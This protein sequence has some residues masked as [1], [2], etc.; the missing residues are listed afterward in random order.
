MPKD[1]DMTTLKNLD[2]RIQKAGIRNPAGLC[3][4]CSATINIQQPT[5]HQFYS[6]GSSL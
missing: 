3:V 2:P 1:F 5:I 4:V 6:G